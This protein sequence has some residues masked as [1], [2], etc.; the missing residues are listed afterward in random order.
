MKKQDTR[1][2][3]QIEKQTAYAKIRLERGDTCEEIMSDSAMEGYNRATLRSLKLRMEKRKIATQPKENKK[4]ATPMQR[5]ATPMQ[6]TESEEKPPKKANF[7]AVFHPADL[8]YYSCVAISGAGI[9]GALHVVG[10]AVA[11]VLFSVAPIA[12]HGIKTVG[13][14]ARLPHLLILTVVE[15]AGFLAHLSWVN[16]A[17]WRDVSKLPF[18]IWQDAYRNNAGELVRLYGGPDLEKPF[19]VACSVSTVL[20]F[21]AVYVCW[22][23]IQGQKRRAKQ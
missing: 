20:F 2:K 5:Y 23:A 16:E 18:E 4:V 3:S 19:F 17:L 22:V 14:W 15:I 7:F 13:G 10:Y 12:L 9:V 1:P 11:G 6:R 21:V 8:L